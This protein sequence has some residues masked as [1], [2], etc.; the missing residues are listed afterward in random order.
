MREAI[1]DAPVFLGL[2]ADV[3]GIAPQTSAADLDDRV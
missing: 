1:P 3:F 2:A